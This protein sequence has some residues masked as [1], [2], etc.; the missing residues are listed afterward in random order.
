MDFNFKMEQRWTS[1]AT[2]EWNDRMIS[3]D[4]RWLNW[5]GVSRRGVSRGYRNRKW[6]L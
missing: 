3:D 1:D 2:R 5:F 4:R 6:E